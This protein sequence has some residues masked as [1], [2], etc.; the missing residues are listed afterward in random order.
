[1]SNAKKIGRSINNPHVQFSQTELVAHEDWAH[2]TLKKAP[3]SALVH[4][5]IKLSGGDETVVASQRTLA[6]ALGVSQST[7]SRAIA[8]AEAAGYIEIIRLGATGRGAC[9]YRLNSRVHWTKGRDGREYF[10]SFRARVVAMGSEQKES[11]E[12]PKPEL[13][14]VPVI[15]TGEVAVPHGPGRAPPSQPGLDG[16]P[17]PAVEVDPS[18][19]DWVGFGYEDDAYDPGMES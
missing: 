9:A 15:R 5:L 16:V 14:K 17:H 18:T 10:T 11:P 13:R 6:E 8:D 2:F 12:I 19:I 4:M 3:A 7:I 1:M